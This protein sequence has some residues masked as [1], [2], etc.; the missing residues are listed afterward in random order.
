MKLIYDGSWMS[1]YYQKKCKL[2]HYGTKHGDCFFLLS[3]VNIQARDFKFIFRLNQILFR[4]IWIFFRISLRILSL[5][6]TVVRDVFWKQVVQY[7]TLMLATGS[8]LLATQGPGTAHRWC[9][10]RA[11][12]TTVN[13]AC[14]GTRGKVRLCPRPVCCQ[15]HCRPALAGRRGWL[16]H[17][18]LHLPGPFDWFAWFA[19]HCT[20]T[21]SIW[22]T[23]GHYSTIVL[24]IFCIPL[25]FWA[26]RQG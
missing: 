15:Q 1:L 9:G 3:T 8:F 2:F 16:L 14:V 7:S 25:H 21:N 12:E 18:P 17:C 23:A 13:A 6:V 20:S 5:L 24:T 10:R 26:A 4:K 11:W 22:L 19:I